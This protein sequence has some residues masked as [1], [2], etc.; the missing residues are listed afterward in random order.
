MQLGVATFGAYTFTNEKRIPKKLSYPA[1]MD[2]KVIILPTM[3]NLL[4]YPLMIGVAICG[5]VGFF[6]NEMGQ[7]YTELVCTGSFQ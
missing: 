2:P 6:A 1:S 3:Y 7:W 5:C 4:S